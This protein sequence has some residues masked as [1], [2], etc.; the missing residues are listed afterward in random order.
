MSAASNLATSYK[1]AYGVR[2]SIEPTDDDAYYLYCVTSETKAKKE[3]V[4]K[5]AY[6]K[7]S[8]SACL[9]YLKTIEQNIKVG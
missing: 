7:G 2:Y 4:K 9:D 5:Q 3:V 8:A 6:F 1:G